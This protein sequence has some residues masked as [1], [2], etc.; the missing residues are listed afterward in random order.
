MKRV[1]LTILCI[2]LCVMSTMTVSAAEVIPKENF[3]EIAES[4]TSTYGTNYFSKTV[5]LN[6]INSSASSLIT[7][8]TGSISG[9]AQHKS[10]Q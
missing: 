8:S 6:S 7:V 4:D 9:N 2:S 5:M 10:L 1:L 3:I